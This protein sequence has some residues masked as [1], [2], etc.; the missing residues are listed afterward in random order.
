MKKA[1]QQSQEGHWTS[2][3]SALQR[4]LT[5][6]EIWHMTPL[7]TSFLIR[8]VYNL[9][10]RVAKKL[11]RLYVTQRFAC[12]TKSNVTSHIFHQVLVWKCCWH[13]YFEEELTTWVS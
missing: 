13:G 8:A 2:C 5:W 7:R 1:V 6:N 4:T 3:K 10:Q 11:Q 12:S 9:Q